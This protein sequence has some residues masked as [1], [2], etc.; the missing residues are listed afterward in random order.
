MNQESELEKIERRKQH[1]PWYRRLTIIFLVTTVLF[2]T[3]SLIIGL[4]FHDYKKNLATG[5]DV[6]LVMD[7][8]WPDDWQGTKF[9]FNDQE[10]HG[11]VISKNWYGKKLVDYLNSDNQ[12]KKLITIESSGMVVAVKSKYADYG[13]FW[14]IQSFHTETNVGIGDLILTQN[15]YFSFVYTSWL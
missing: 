15:N 4:R 1:S 14:Q 7:I 12:I 8:K 9:D 2:A 10:Y 5:N 13:F 6:S 3:L 11:P